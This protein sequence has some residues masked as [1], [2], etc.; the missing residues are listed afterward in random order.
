M[1]LTLAQFH[2]HLGGDALKPV[3]LLAGD[4]H[5]LLLEAA[6]ALRARARALGYSER[7]AQAACKELPPDIGVSDGIRAALKKLSRA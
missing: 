5:L 7:E 1:S 6:D 4:E 2:K 3:Y